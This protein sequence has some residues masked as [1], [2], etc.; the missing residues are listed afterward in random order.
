MTLMQFFSG[1]E[2]Q[3]LDAAVNPDA[4]AAVASWERWSSQTTLEDAQYPERRL[5]SAV[6]GH[7]SLIAPGVDLPKKMRGKARATLASNHMIARA[8]VHLCES[9]GAASPV[10]FSEAIA[11]CLRFD[12]WATR[13][14]RAA[15][16]HL[17][18]AALKDVEAALSTIGW[19]LQ[20]GELSPAL[21]G[22]EAAAFG[23]LT[24]TKGRLGVR[25]HWSRSSE[26]KD[27]P[28]TQGM[29]ADAENVLYL[30]RSVSIQ[31][32]EDSLVA[33]L[34]HRLRSDDRSEALLAVVDA[35]W[36]LP[37]CRPDRLSSHLA[38][39]S[40][41]GAFHE[42]AALLQ[43]LG[44]PKEAISR[45]STSS[46]SPTF[47]GAMASDASITARHIPR[48]RTAAIRALLMRI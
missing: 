14:V 45:V 17:P 36:L 6:Y 22:P 8:T 26:G 35:A 44:M 46:S 37:V 10:L 13:D 2:L 48:R 24:A 11:I 9:L 12:A 18:A 38:A 5:L 39:A 28:L 16:I 29:W 32:A 30:G 25:I 20:S 47:D 43:E 1:R 41:T 34:R 33:I 19:H 7:L 42:L 21:T 15:D 4:A 23:S 40:L 31:S 27:C 3:L